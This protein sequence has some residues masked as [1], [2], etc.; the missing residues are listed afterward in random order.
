MNNNAL[1]FDTSFLPDFPIA[2]VRDY[3]ATAYAGGSWTGKGLTSSAAAA[4]SAATHKTA[5]GYADAGDLFTS[6]PAIWNGTVV[7]DPSILVRYTYAGDANLDGTV[8]TLDFNAL[9]GHFG[10]TGEQWSH[11]D[12]NYDGIIDTLDFNSLAANFGQA[13]PS[14]IGGGGGMA[15]TAALVPEPPIAS[16]AGA[17]ACFAARR[18]IRGSQRL[19]SLRV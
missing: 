8:D 11:G 7:E 15:P 1:V 16:L 9:A 5:L 13:L 3:I 12:F 17:A 6:F 10:A 4:Q 19:N 18:K 2:R 14:D